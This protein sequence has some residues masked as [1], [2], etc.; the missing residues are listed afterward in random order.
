MI[1]DYFDGLVK[2]IRE[3]RKKPVPAIKAITMVTMSIVTIISIALA[4]QRGAP[5][6]APLIGGYMFI[7]IWFFV[8]SG[9]VKIDRRP[10]R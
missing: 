10:R 8:A 9:F 3:V 6:W 7:A 5:Y 1:K 4:S 2:T